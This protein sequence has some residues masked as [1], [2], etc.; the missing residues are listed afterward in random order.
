M[1]V[2]TEP[3]VGDD[4]DRRGMH[5]VAED[6]IRV[7]RIA[8]ALRDPTGA[9]GGATDSA[10]DT[11]LALLDA[12]AEG[13]EDLTAHDL[14]DRLLDV[15]DASPLADA[16]RA[17]G[18]DHPA[19]P[20]HRA[21]GDPGLSSSGPRVPR[22]VAT[23]DGGATAA[24]AG[25]PGAPRTSGSGPASRRHRAPRATPTR[26]AGEA[27]RAART[28][29]RSELGRVRPR[30]WVL[31]SAT[32][33]V[34]AAAALVLP[35]LSGS[36]HGASGGDRAAGRAA[37]TTGG[38]AT[39]AGT[40]ETDPPASAPADATTAHAD[41]AADADADADAIASMDP[42]AAAPALL[43]LRAACFQQADATCLES[44]D[45]RG[46]A[47][48]DADRARIESRDAAH[49]GGAGLHQADH[50]DPAQRLGDTALIA[51][52]PTGDGDAP[53]TPG[54]RP[55]SLLVIRG[56]AGWRIRDLMDDR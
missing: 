7:A 1:D 49:A 54:R 46:S 34:V 12:A 55:A 16:S 10:W 2:D 40:R 17:D 26:R 44:V 35:A 25:G 22:P 28:I 37:A 51:L 20:T 3:G 24:R 33:V 56:E 19:G 9:R 31:G 50:L 23:G 6:L 13:E 45:Q 48:E 30:V 47:A 29:V 14:A 5:P 52:H 53:T 15:A 42:D 18:L 38:P 4:E 21:T 41:A 8:S 39:I 27:V 32:L 36:A 43:R 11:W